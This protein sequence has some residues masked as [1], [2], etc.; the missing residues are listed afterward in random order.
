M[1]VKSG[2][3]VWTGTLKEGSGTVSSQSGALKE[4]PYGFNTRFGDTP[5]TNPE[6]LIGAAHAACF[7]MALSN[8]MG[9]E[10]ITAE[11]IAT[12]SKITLEMLDD[13]PTVTKA[14][15][16]TEIK[17]PA[18]EALLLDLAAKAKAGCP[19]SRLLNAEITMEAKVL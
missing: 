15:L 16:V 7:S 9:G 6:E 4:L 3:A 13:G 19:I 1:I 5:G 10:G 17:A 12:T 18:D 2:S 8:I 14:H 11:R